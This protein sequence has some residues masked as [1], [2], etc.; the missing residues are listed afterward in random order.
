MSGAAPTAE[1]QEA[2]I[3]QLKQQMTQQVSEEMRELPSL[4]PRP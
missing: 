1:Q 3:N 2:Y 4:I